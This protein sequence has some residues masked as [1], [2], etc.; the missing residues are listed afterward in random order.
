LLT[1]VN[2]DVA[3][4]QTD[5]LPKAGVVLRNAPLED[6][7]VSTR[8]SPTFWELIFTEGGLIVKLEMTWVENT[9]PS[10]PVNPTYA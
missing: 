2:G 4:V 10:A 6:G 3:R 7:H 9:P 5:G 1:T 8:L